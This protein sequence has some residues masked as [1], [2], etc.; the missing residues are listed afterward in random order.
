MLRT[1]FFPFKWS[2]RGSYF[3]GSTC[4][5]PESTP[6]ERGKHEKEVKKN[7]KTTKTQSVGIV[8]KTERDSLRTVEEGD[9]SLE[10]LH[11]QIALVALHLTMLHGGSIQE[12][13]ELDGL[14]GGSAG[15]VL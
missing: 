12:I 15:L 8:V 14:V 4:L 2:R 5:K 13:V 3:S 7:K 6:P 1:F 9:L 10:V 11:E